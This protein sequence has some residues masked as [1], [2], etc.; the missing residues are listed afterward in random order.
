MGVTGCLDG[1]CRRDRSSDPG[2]GRAAVAVPRGAAV[3]F[4]LV[5]QSRRR[6]SSHRATART[7]VVC[8]AGVHS[9]AAHASNALRFARTCEATSAP[10][11]FN[12][13]ARRST[14]CATSAGLAGRA[15]I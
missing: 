8:L 9:A 2:D 5:T 15:P 3:G 1:R 4:H 12:T 11:R 10:V 13:A 14:V 7:T 6:L